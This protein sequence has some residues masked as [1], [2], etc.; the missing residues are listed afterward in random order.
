[1]DILQEYKDLYYKELEICDRL[2]N[3]IGT[4]LTLLSIIGAGQIILWKDIYLIKFEECSHLLYLVLSAISLIIYIIA[5]CFFKKA[6]TGYKY[7]YLPISGINE[8]VENSKNYVE[9]NGIS[10]NQMNNYIANMFTR[11]YINNTI[12]NRKHNLTK[13]KYQYKLTRYICFAF[14]ALFLAYSVW[15]FT[16]NPIKENSNSNYIIINKEG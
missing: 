16:I 11:K 6:Y 5:I 7:E 9:L 3:K 1:M 14:I 12:I 10:E 8:Y 2:N 4:A 15:T 13:I